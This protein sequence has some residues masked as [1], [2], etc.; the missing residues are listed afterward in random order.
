[1]AAE[2]T[3]YFRSLLAA[4]GRQPGWYGVFAEREPDAAAA[5]GSGRR[6]P[7]WDVVRTVLRDVAANGG[8]GDADPA[9]VGRAYALHRA[10]AAAEDSAPGASHALRGRLDAAIRARDGAAAR[11]G[12]GARGYEEAGAETAGPAGARLANGLAWARDDLSR[13]AARCEELRGRLA[14]AVGAARL[15]RE[16]AGAGTGVAG[17]DDAGAAERSE[18]PTVRRPTGAR[19]AGSGAAVPS[20]SPVA[21]APAT[22]ARV[23]SAAPRGARFAGAP[24]ADAVGEAVLPAPSARP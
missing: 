10:A 9:E 17:S 23:R 19:F 14:G 20:G 24:T 21:P 5:Y 22:A 7:P 3:Y 2:F 13:A 12:A 18:A 11:A 8:A 6:L 15:G 16:A 4:L 1:M